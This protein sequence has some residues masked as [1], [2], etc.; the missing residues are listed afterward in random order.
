MTEWINACFIRGGTSKGLFFNAADLPADD[1]DRDAA[2]C[3]VMGSPDPHGRQLNGMGGGI[4][5]LSKVMLVT[6]STREGFYVDYTF[7]QVEVGIDHI[8]YSGNCGN[9]SSGV[10]PFALEAGIISSPDGQQEF[11]LF[12]TNTSKTVT[13]T[14]EVVNGRAAPAGAATSGSATSGSATSGAVELPGVAGTGSPIQLS[15]P[16]PAGSRTAGLLPTG[17]P[18]N[19]LDD[20]GSAITVSLVDSTLH[21]VIVRAA[22]VGLSG[23]ELPGELDAN[24]P[25]M[26]LLERLRQAGAAAMGFQ[27]CPEVVPKI[28]VIAPPQDSTTLDGADL[29]ADSVDIMVRMISMGKAHLAVPGTGAMCL[30]AAAAVPGTLVSDITGHHST[31]QSTEHSTEHSIVR[32]GTPSGAVIAAADYA[33]GELASTTL[34]RTARI[35][36]RGQVPLDSDR[37]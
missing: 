13:V 8:D 5:S 23:T 10:I 11:Q 6:A 15:Y 30:A 21:V 37:A 1:A 3:H 36:M 19:V 35:L 24:R 27:T 33:D 4:S 26:A 29:D 18:T 25:A 14:L 2:L 28:A 17:S 31:E 20:D 22:D 7:G 32:L 9:L 12:N 16:S 34:I